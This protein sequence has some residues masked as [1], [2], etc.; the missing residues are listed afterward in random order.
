[1]I[2]ELSFSNDVEKMAVSGYMMTD[3]KF[4]CASKD[5][6]DHTFC[7]IMFD[8]RCTEEMPVEY[9]LIDGVSVRGK[10]GDMKVFISKSRNESYAK[11]MDNPEHWEEV[12]TSYQHKSWRALTLLSFNTQV[13]LRPGELLAIYVHSSSYGDQAVVYDNQR[14]Y[15]GKPSAQDEFISVFP[16]SAHLQSEPFDSGV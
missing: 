1:M 7:G 8:I 14:V 5:N 13:V 3:Q 12:H 16:G 15:E 9:L 4:T 6:Q 10:L 11:L 2:D